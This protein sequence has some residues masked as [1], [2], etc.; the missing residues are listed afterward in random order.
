MTIAEDVL[1]QRLQ[2]VLTLYE[3]GED[4]VCLEGTRQ[5]LLARAESWIRQPNSSPEHLF[6]VF[7]P[8][9]TGKSAFA[10]TIAQRLDVWNEVDLT[11]Y[12]CE[13][14]DPALSDPV[15]LL[16]SIAYRIA[17]KHEEYRD[18]L[19]KALSKNDRTPT[20]LHS[21]RKQYKQLLGD[22]LS[23]VAQPSRPL[24][25]VI[26]G[27]D[28]CCHPPYLHEPAVCILELAE[29]VPWIKLLVTSI[30]EPEQYITRTLSKDDT[31]VIDINEEEEATRDNKLF[32]RTRLAKLN[33]ATHFD[34]VHGLVQLARGQF[35]LCRTIFKYLQTSRNPRRDLENLLTE[36]AGQAEEEQ[37]YHLYDC[38]L[39]HAAQNDK[40][41][42][43]VVLGIIYVSSANCPLSA[44]AISS[45]L[46]HD[47]HTV[48]EDSH[49]ILSL[50]QKLHAVL[51]EQTDPRVP[52][53]VRHPSFLSYLC[54]KLDSGFFVKLSEIHELMATGC[55]KTL[56]RELRFN[57][58]SL[59]D[60]YRLNKDVPDLSKRIQEHISEVLQYSS[61]FWFDH[62]S[63]CDSTR[64]ISSASVTSLVT[65]PKILHWLE[66]LSWLD[67]LA[68][69]VAILRR[70]SIFFKV[71]RLKRAL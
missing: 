63:L 24:L 16:A 47:R 37:L 1:L 15:K 46:Q 14:G 9:G 61:L 27:L 50:T 68:E 31:C 66:V 40:Y 54:K 4:Y 21:F 58:C 32:I 71:C 6:W 8:A 2:P 60:S 28:A 35:F 13:R 3:T 59:E 65:S 36:M 17:C 26:D 41:T 62:V 22:L 5:S 34:R 39:D 19:L 20:A 33:L 52:F 38:I 43:H 23:D 57:I 12:R 49:S 64:I 48:Y 51:S 56:H 70:G 25:L 69:G 67:A 7:G 44:E 42:Q 53:R 11:F 30:H 29:A 45:F 55:L 18:R 10:N